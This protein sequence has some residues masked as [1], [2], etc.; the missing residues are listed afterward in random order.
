MKKTMKEL[1]PRVLQHLRG[2]V[3]YLQLLPLKILVSLPLELTNHHSD[4]PSASQ[5]NLG[6]TK[7]K[8]LSFYVT[9]YNMFSK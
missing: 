2:T 9:I 4:F 7:I 1:A 8:L 5:I 3:E 6:Q